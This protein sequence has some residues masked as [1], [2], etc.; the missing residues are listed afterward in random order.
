MVNTLIPYGTVL[1]SIATIVLADDVY[2][3][4]DE[5]CNRAVEV[6]ADK[7]PRRKQ[8]NSYFIN[9]RRK[10]LVKKVG[11]AVFALLSRA[12]LSPAMTW[13][14]D[15][16]YGDYVVCVYPHADDDD[17]ELV[18]DAVMWL[19]YMDMVG[20]PRRLKLETKY[21][22]DPDYS[23]DRESV[24]Q[25]LDRLIIDKTRVVT[26]FLKRLGIVYWAQC[27]KAQ[28]GIGCEVLLV[29]PVESLHRIKKR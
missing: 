21:D 29:G 23:Y 9:Q 13:R 28:Y 1:R 26:E 19:S 14:Y 3:T 12:G 22:E 18:A 24:V 17:F 2:I 10:A 7:I 27:N 15:R 25:R 8:H 5:S 11:L 4:T 16:R 20:T 6:H